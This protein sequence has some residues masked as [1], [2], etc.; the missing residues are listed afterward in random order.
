VGGD[1]RTKSEQFSPLTRSRLTGPRPS[2]LSASF[3]AINS[4]WNRQFEY[5][6]LQRGG[7]SNPDDLAWSGQPGSDRAWT[8]RIKTVTLS[9]ALAS[10]RRDTELFVLGKLHDSTGAECPKSRIVK[11]SGTATS[12]PPMPV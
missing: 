4:S 10:S 7:G 2:R 9:P 1:G 3:A 12:A 11:D 8:A 5:P 6:P